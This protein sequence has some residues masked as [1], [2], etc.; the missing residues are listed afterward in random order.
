MKIATLL[1]ISGLLVHAAP[2]QQPAPADPILQAMREEIERAKMLRIVSLDAPYFIE[3]GVDDV[4]SFSVSASFGGLLAAR[5]SRL[6]IPRIQVRVGNYDFDNTNYVFTDLFH[7]PRFDTERMVLDNDVRA[8]RT[9]FWLATDRAYKGSLQ[10]IARKRSALKNLSETEK[11]NDFA[12]A[13]PFRMVLNLYKVQVDQAFWTSQVK[14]LSAIFTQY[15]ALSTGTVDFE[16]NYGG[17]YLMNSE[18]TEV[19]MTDS[20]TYVR[21]RASTRTA[22]GMP[23][24]DALVFLAHTPAG[25]PPEAE[26]RRGVAEVATNV[27]ALASAPVGESYVG[28]VLFEPMA[29]AQLFAQVL[30]RN[31]SLTRR[32]VGE[33]G[34]NFPF[35][36]SEFEGREGSRVLPEW[37]DVVDDPTQREF[38]GKA[39]L[40]YYPVDMEGVPPEPL[41]L[42]EK[43]V[44]KNFLLTRQPV[45]GFEGS[46]G[47]ARLPGGFGAKYATFGNLFIRASETVT[48]S[49][50][51]ARLIEMCKQR[52]KPYGLLIRKLDFPSSASLEELRRAAGGQGVHGR[53]VSPPILVY[54]V[55]P[56]GREELVRGLRFRGLS[57]RSLRDIVAASDE[58]YMFDYLENGA[59][60]SLIGSGTY[61]APS[62][63]ISPAVLFEDLDLEPY[64]EP[65][66]TPPVVPPPPLI[67]ASR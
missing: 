28:P 12:R 37:M 43:G 67:P 18:G 2:A 55:Y 22:D 3:Y 64:S 16:S 4:E 7:G 36:P 46:N 65:W 19:R 1:A 62:T 50:L 52:N 21:I 32:P 30:G 13:K 24:R 35:V 9:H 20:L 56:D 10:A 66:P 6:R 47:R 27:T 11:I 41:T 17:S 26:L 63:V 5:P 48:A 14:K 53:P 40:G 38:R 42:I 59:P 29:A 57:T 61:V 54:R 15:P 31:L 45:R 58:A 39:L 34:R 25:L 8:L 44:L 60:F 23:V 33:P 51:K 49:E